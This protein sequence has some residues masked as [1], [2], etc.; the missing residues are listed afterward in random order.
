MPAEEA[1]RNKWFSVDQG[2][3]D[4]KFTLEQAQ[5]N[6]WISHRVLKK[7]ILY[8]TNHRTLVKDAI[9]AGDLTVAEAISLKYIT[10]EQVKKAPWLKQVKVKAESTKR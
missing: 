8:N 6:G 9:E 3:A 2:I 10:E 1:L 7:G 4:N 5:Q